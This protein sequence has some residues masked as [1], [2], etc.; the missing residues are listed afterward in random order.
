[1]KIVIIGG[2]GNISTPIVKLLLEQGHDVTAYNRGQR[3][4]LPEG[5]R[6][7]VGDRKNREE[8]EVTMQREKFDVAID[9]ICFNRE[10]AES[11]VRAFRDVQQ[12]IQTSTVVTYG[13]RLRWL[14]AT[15]DHP[16]LSDRPY[17]KGKSE[18]DAYY[19]QAY[20][21]DGFPVTIIKPS[22]THGPKQGLIRQ[23][24][25]DYS[26]IDRIRKGKPIL[27][28]GDGAALHQF[29]HVDDA[30]LAYA[31]VIGK[32]HCIGQVYNMVDQGFVTWA[33]YHR[34]AMRV[35]GREVELVGIP[36]ADLMALNVPRSEICADIFAHHV[37]YSADKIF[38]DVPEFRPRL[39]LAAAM[40]DIIAALDAENRIPNSDEIKWEDQ[41]IAAQR[42]VRETRIDV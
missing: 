24:A 27:V 23:I 40:E 12:F 17:G 35:L 33:E 42:K 8:F 19:L 22:T 29:L 38:R 15:E 26:W 36:L 28:C 5:A 10:D 41:I 39:S 9:M 31:G 20:Y 2:T 13:N 14:P 1:M 18:A 21:R 34:T 25:W 32:T 4:N 3:G 37:I 16:T 30:A 7:L 11:N 6:L